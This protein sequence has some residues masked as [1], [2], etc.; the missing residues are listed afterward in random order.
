MYGIED[1]KKAEAK[2]EA[3]VKAEAKNNA[4]L[5]MNL[6]DS[7]VKETKVGQGDVK[8]I[9]L[10]VIPPSDKN[11]NSTIDAPKSDVSDPKFGGVN[12]ALEE[13]VGAETSAKS[14]ILASPN[15]AEDIA[16][17]GT[18]NKNI[19]LFNNPSTSSPPKELDKSKRTETKE[20]MVSVIE[21][22]KLFDSGRNN[23]IPESPRVDEQIPQIEVPKAGI[24]PNAVKPIGKLSDDEQNDGTFSPI[25]SGRKNSLKNI[26][27]EEGVKVN[28]EVKTMP[29]LQDMAGGREGAGSNLE[30][31]DTSA[32]LTKNNEV[33]NKISINKAEEKDAPSLDKNT[34]IAP[35][36][37]EEENNENNLPGDSG[38]PHTDLLES[39]LPKVDAREPSSDR[40]QSNQ[41]IGTPISSEVA[42]I[43]IYSPPDKA[44]NES[45]ERSG[46]EG[47]K[48]IPQTKV[49]NALK[50]P[51][52]LENIGGQS[53]EEE[54][55]GISSLSK[56]SEASSPNFI[57]EE[58]RA[59][60]KSAED[61][62]KAE[63]GV[64]VK[65][66]VEAIPDL[67]VIK[68]NGKGSGSKLK[69]RNTSAD[70]TENTEV[71]NEISYQNSKGASDVNSSREDPP[72][73][74]VPQVDALA[75]GVVPVGSNEDV[76]KNPALYSVFPRAVDNF[77]P[78]PSSDRC[79]SNQRIGT[80]ISSEIETYLSPDKAF[81]ESG[82]RNGEEVDKQIPQIEVPNALEVPK[83]LESIGGPSDEMPTSFQAAQIETSPAKALKESDT[84][85]VKNL[86]EELIELLEKER[87]TKNP[88]SP[89]KNN[90]Q[91]E[92]LK[93]ANVEEKEVAPSSVPKS[94]GEE[95]E[96]H[97]L[98]YTYEN[99]IIKFKI[100]SGAEDSGDKFYYNR[101]LSESEKIFHNEGVEKFISTKFSEVQERKNILE[102]L[103]QAKEATKQKFSDE[104]DDDFFI[105]VMRV[106]AKKRG[107]STIK[108]EEEFNGVLK[109]LNLDLETSRYNLK[110]GD[111]L[112]KIAKYFS[113][114]FQS[115]SK[116]NKYFTARERENGE[117]N[118]TGR[119]LF[120]VCTEENIQAMQA[121]IVSSSSAEEVEKQLEVH[122][123]P[124]GS[125]SSPSKSSVGSS[126]RTPSSQ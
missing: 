99:G 32:Y 115:L 94:S 120:R 125:P 3:E 92:I 39:P 28:S 63:A 56:S 51:K 121:Q 106:A 36:K 84:K 57:E 108:N 77:L 71:H 35:T 67:Q 114:Q 107:I 97:S 5:M 52:N 111:T 6:T 11:K 58:V 95:G 79:Q 42:P 78:L 93:V 87:D 50:A 17:P 18:V 72:H 44:F 105:A 62:A 21:Q 47:N 75:E 2:A 83:E 80:P 113:A 124:R 33:H 15:P 112:R 64:K 31:R 25:R 117:F 48:K 102:L 10:E 20:D 90:I 110:D 14:N 40:C 69:D 38:V 1:E 74:P 104:I 68:G 86:V 100:K 12:H 24:D 60:F 49:S 59:P 103:N 109:S 43:E 123:N 88:K 4:S 19:S 70:L 91:T 85:E 96:K 118:E 89:E 16:P 116:D 34:I 37:M 65:A 27:A 7:S 23:E 26:E 53:D 122:H 9:I 8:E 82:E 61:G 81:N 119:R 41:K 46:E 30:Y 45:G 13:V 54:K 29:T 22:R 66:E 126:S 101:Q 55:N 98:P 73:S 76:A